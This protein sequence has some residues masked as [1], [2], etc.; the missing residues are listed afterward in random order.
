MPNGRH[1]RPPPVG[2]GKTGVGTGGRGLDIEH[3]ARN[4]D[5]SEEITITQ[6][7]WLD[8]LF[9]DYLDGLGFVLLEDVE[10]EHIARNPETGEEVTFTREEW[11]DKSFRDDLKERG[12]ERPE[13]EPD[14]DEIEDA[15]FD[16][17]EFEAEF[18]EDEEDED[19]VL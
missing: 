14:L 10:R 12:F 11:M 9:R 3:V 2:A 19:E 6:R 15:E 7:E 1:G 13:D 8:E 17:E 5:T 4:P 18:E 16:L